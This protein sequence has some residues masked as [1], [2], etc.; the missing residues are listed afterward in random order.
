MNNRYLNYNNDILIKRYE[1]LRNEVI[2]N[3]IS[4]FAEMHIS[5]NKGHALFLRQGMIGWV[6]AWSLCKE[7]RP[8][9]PEE[10]TKQVHNNPV[11]DDIKSQV[12]IILANM[13]LYS[14]KEVA[15]LC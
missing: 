11:T 7:P 12:T 1:E 2:N 14:K 6:K 15:T 4:Q 3:K 8:A 13:A 5:Q 9:L 10:P